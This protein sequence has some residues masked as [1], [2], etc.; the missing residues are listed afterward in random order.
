MLSA[1]FAVIDS[2]NNSNNMVKKICLIAMAICL[3]MPA[4][5]CFAQAT[6]DGGIENS[7]SEVTISLNG[8]TVTIRNAEG[9]AVELYAITGVQI[10]SYRIGRNQK[11]L[12]LT[13]KKGFYIIKVNKM[14]RRITI[15]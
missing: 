14:T 11:E 15:P 12:V 4:S 8:S 9:Q 7:A 6:E 5:T 1:I 3:W 2:E 10:A 13:L